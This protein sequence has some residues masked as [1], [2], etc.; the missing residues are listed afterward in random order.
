VSDKAPI[1]N[2][3]ATLLV[4]A[5]LVVAAVV[6]GPQLYRFLAD[7][8]AVQRWVAGFGAWGPLVSVLLN[9]AQV[10]L[11][12][13]PGQAVGLANGYLYGVV[14]GTLYSLLGVMLGSALAMILGRRFGRPLVVR[15]VGEERLTSLDR[16]ARRQG[17]AFFFLV[18]VF[19]FV[20][21]DL[22]CFVIG[23]SPLPVA[24]ML[25]LS[26]LG[27]L[28]GLVIASWVGANA[29]DLPWWGWVLLGAGGAA[30]ALIFWRYQERLERLVMDLIQ[31][32]VRRRDDPLHRGQ[33]E[34]RHGQDGIDHH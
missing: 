21:D 6:W 33:E 18:F 2:R 11:A 5:L 4:V 7:R 14:L 1:R 13:I 30:L 31:R 20:P 19:P 23:L 8:E 34:E 29:T 26:A 15:L 24:Q 17:P 27:R 22:A 32:L 9:V 16:I 25:A 3:V 12:P 28:P 10:L